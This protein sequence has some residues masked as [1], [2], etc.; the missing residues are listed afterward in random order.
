MEKEELSAKAEEEKKQQ[1]KVIMKEK[2]SA[3]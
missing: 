2:R 1:L 3:Y